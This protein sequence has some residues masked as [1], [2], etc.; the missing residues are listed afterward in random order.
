MQRAVKLSLAVAATVLCASHYN[1]TMVD[2]GGVDALKLKP[3]TALS[4]SQKEEE[5][6]AWYKSP[7]RKLLNGQQFV[8]YNLDTR[9]IT[10]RETDGSTLRS[11][12][13]K[14]LDLKNLVLDKDVKLP[15]E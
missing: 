12:D 8:G 9:I 15:K 14:D 1:P 4:L 6:L 3:A 10:L 13:L 11:V 2:V 5:L 7:H